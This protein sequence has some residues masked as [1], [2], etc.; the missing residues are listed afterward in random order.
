MIAMTD[1]TTIEAIRGCLERM[2]AEFSRW[3]EAY[4]KGPGLY[5]AVV[6]RDVD[7]YARPLGGNRW[8]V[9][10]GANVLEDGEAF[11]QAASAVAVHC[12][13][14][15]VVRHDGTAHEQ[16]VRFADLGDAVEV[17][18]Q[19]EDWMGTRHVSAVET[20]TRP[21]VVATLTLSEE[22]GRLTE[23]RDGRVMAWLPGVDEAE[24]PLSGV[25]VA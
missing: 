24:A 3:G 21:G 10:R 9:E 19:Y 17:T 5:V 13:G 11:Y 15:V 8:P 22:T 1:D 2:R 20:S 23:F 7:E 14:A 12:D 18:P 6:E 25:Q 4:V 16:M